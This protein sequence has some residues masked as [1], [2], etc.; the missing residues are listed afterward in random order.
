[1]VTCGVV[2]VVHLTWSNYRTAI[3]INY[4]Y[5]CIDSIKCLLEVKMCAGIG[6]M[7]AIVLFLW[8]FQGLCIQS[9]G[10]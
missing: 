4:I 6:S 10:T 1:M 7:G 5:V 8:L 9:F 2:D 3:G